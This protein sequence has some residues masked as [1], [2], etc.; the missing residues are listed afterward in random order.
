MDPIVWT[1]EMSVGSEALDDHHRMIIACLNRLQPLLGA[2]G[3]QEEIAAVMST[4]EEFVL[5]HFSEEERAMK[6]AGF[7]GWRAHKDLHDKMYDVVFALK[8]DIEKGD[9]PDAQQLY[10][11]L[12][13]WLV[14]HILGE[15]RKYVPFLAAPRDEVGTWHRANGRE[16]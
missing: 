1:N 9:I 7:P 4:L 2:E 13:D 14:H 10:A 3:R 16:V 8:A 12:Q 5:V 11:M 15:D 6:R